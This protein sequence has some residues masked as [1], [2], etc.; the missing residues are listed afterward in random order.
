MPR[1]PSIGLAAATSD[2]KHPNLNQD[3]PDLNWATALPL[4]IVPAA[5]AQLGAL[6]TVLATRLMHDVSGCAEHSLAADEWNLSIEDMERMTGQNRR[7]LFAHAN[8]LPFIKRIT[9]KKL[10]GDAALL[11]RWI[12]ERRG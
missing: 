6:Q 2:K 5:I 12:A 10:R 9:K 8:E 4:E 1:K 7:W 11:K 3:F